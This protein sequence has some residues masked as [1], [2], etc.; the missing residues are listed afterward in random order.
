MSTLE[1]DLNERMPPQKHV[2]LPDVLQECVAR[3]VGFTSSRQTFRPIIEPL[4]PVRIYTIHDN[5]DITE[6]N[7]T[8]HYSSMNNSIMYN[9]LLQTTEHEGNRQ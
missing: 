6:D 3:N 8:P 5:V 2:L 1:V 4:Q 7:L 9:L